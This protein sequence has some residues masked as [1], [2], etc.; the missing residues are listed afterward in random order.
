MATQ[1]VDFPEALRQLAALAGIELSKSKA[2]PRGL[3]ELRAAAMNCAL[4]FFLS[5]LGKNKAAQQYCQERGLTR[6]V[7]DRFEIGYAPDTGEALASTLKRK[8]IALEE[9]RHVFLVDKDQ[10]GGYFDRFRGRLIFPIRNEHGKLVA[11]GGR[12]LGVGQPKYINSG[13][14]PLYS[15]RQ[16]LYGFHLAKDAVALTKRIVLVEGYMD[17]IACH[18]AGINNAVAS[19][20]TALSEDHAALLSRWCGEVVVLYDSDAAGLAAA[21]RAAEVCKEARLRVRIALIPAGKD[22]DSIVQELGPETLR[23][24]CDSSVSHLDFRI[25]QI[26][27]ARN[28]QEPEFWEEVVAA[29]SMSDNHLEVDKHVVRLS[30]EYP[31]LRDAKAAQRSLYRQIQAQRKVK[32]RSVQK[33]TSQPIALQR[34]FDRREQAVFAALLE[35]DL[36][37]E[38]WSAIQM[39]GIFS[40]EYAEKLGAYLLE[41]FQ[42]EAPTGDAVQVLGAVK[43]ED[44]RER[45][46]AMVIGWDGPI[47]SHVLRQAITQ[48]QSKSFFEVDDQLKSLIE[49]QDSSQRTEADEKLREMGEQLRKS[50]ADAARLFNERRAKT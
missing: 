30:S 45:L 17:A 46:S 6:E 48:L 16:V 37:I 11:F 40:T 35:P 50:K 32:K 3:G 20:G 36:R 27:Q 28:Q 2:E 10:S 18:V 31:G 19:L 22:P 7:L 4:E 29:L 41:V 34:P 12:I 21:E 49:S 15:K 43:D 25:H 24:I 39:P 23:K 8:G 44:F 9:A 26:R 1:H 33:P 14:T 5:E 38:A 42:G 13:E 47:D